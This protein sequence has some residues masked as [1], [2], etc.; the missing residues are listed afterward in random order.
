MKKRKQKQETEYS[1]W[2][3]ATDLMSSLAFILM[4]VIALL[5]LYILSDY[6]GYTEGYYP[7]QETSAAEE[8]TVQHEGDGD[9]SW[10]HDDDHG[11]GDGDGDGSGDGQYDEQIIQTGGGG[12]S[13]DEGIKSAVFAELVDDETDR[14]IPEAG[15]SFE[16]YRTDTVNYQDGAL[17]ILNTYY[18][19]KISYRDFETT[20]EGTFYLPEKIYQGTYFFRELNEPE[21]YDAAGDTYFDIDRLYDWPEAYIVQL[22]VSPSKNIIYVQSSD[23]ATGEP[24]PGASYDVIA[25]ENVA[26]NDGT[27]R[28]TA[29]QLADTI[30]CDEDGKGQSTELYLGKYYLRQSQVPEYY[31]AMPGTLAVS[32]DKK[33]T[34]DPEQHNVALDKTAVNIKVNDELYQDQG[35]AG[36]EFVLTDASGTAAADCT[37]DESGSVR[38]TDLSKNTVYHLRQ[39]KAAGDYYADSADHTFTVDENGLIDNRSTLDLAL[40]NRMIRVAV[41]QIDAVLGKPVSGGELSLY[42]SGNNLISTW[43]TG[44][45][46]A[47]FTDLAPGHYYIVRDKD[48]DKR[49]E[50]DVN[51]TAAM[52]ELNIRVF[53]INSA[54]AAAAAVLILFVA[55]YAFVSLI[56]LLGAKKKRR[57]LAAASKADKKEDDEE[58][59][60]QK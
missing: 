39:T 28:F 46:A 27:V 50:F 49:S 40:S 33:G 2:Q 41:G 47:V 60:E 6:T 18:P 17:Q 42:D 30:V 13:P 59:R 23:A 12:Y 44:K 22:R 26:T 11:S 5:G 45:S 9:G 15:I 4:L 32:V 54:L 58:S 56:K 25:A 21:G 16:L 36:A 55:I 14:I 52:Q 8:T 38:L 35:I 43:T 3:P 29:G 48:T 34:A 37:T 20:E 31:A 24:L 19:E 53:T 51:D 7:A 10:Y 57:M 1:F